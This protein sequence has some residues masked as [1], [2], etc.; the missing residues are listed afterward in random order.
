MRCLL[1]LSL[2]VLNLSACVGS[3]AAG[4]QTC[5]EG[6]CVNIQL[7]E[8]IRL[9]TPVTTLVTVQTEREV[10]G[11]KVFLPTSNRSVLVE[12]EPQWTVNAQSRKSMSANRVIRFTEEG[13]F[14]V[15]AYAQD[16]ITGTVVKSYVIVHITDA[17]GKIYLPGTPIPLGTPEKPIPAVTITPGPSPTRD[18]K[19]VPSPPP[20]KPTGTAIPTPIQRSYP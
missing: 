20:L 12:G 7:S 13:F 14:E 11:L 15:M 10:P 1:A 19:Y 16:P 2:L 9:N 18:P 8:P 4:G 17:G 5:Q 3:S 6:I